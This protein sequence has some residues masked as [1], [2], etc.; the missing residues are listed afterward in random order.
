M[1]HTR[2]LLI[3]LAFLAVGM[4]ISAQEKPFEY[5]DVFDL[6][7]ASDPQIHPEG[8]WIVYR[9]MGF[10]V[11]ED[12]SRGNLWMLRADGSSHQKV[13]TRETDEYSPRWSP[14]GDRMAFV[15]RTDEGAEIY[16]YWQDSG[17]YARLTQLPS[18]PS[19]LSWSPDGSQLAFTMNVPEAAPVL[20]KMPKKP[21]KWIFL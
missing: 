14:Q 11:L 1:K 9:R 20:A 4:A 3:I 2:S 10:D 18:S 5:M 19:S 12:R 7:Y 8:E 21:K 6:Q 13:T 16:L 15:S 17:R